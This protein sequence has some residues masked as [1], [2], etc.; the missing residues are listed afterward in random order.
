MKTSRMMSMLGAAMTL[1]A[2]ASA[3][4]PEGGI[5][6]VVAPGVE[7]RLVK[8]GYMFTEGPLG[9]ADGG[10][11]F[12]DLRTANRIYRLD[13]N[14]K[15]SV[16]LEN[17]NN[18]NGLAFT[19]SG[20]LLAAEGGGKRISRIAPDGRVTEVSRG[21][22]ERPLMSPNDLIVDAKDGIYFTDPGPRPV[23][24]GR[25]AYV[26]YLPPGASKAIAQDDAIIRPNGLTI[27]LDGKTLI[28]ADTVGDTLYAFDIHAD[29]SLANRRPFA[30]IQDVPE[31][32]DSGGDGVAIDREG[33]LFV[34]SL[35]GVQVFSRTGDYL[36]TIRVP[37]QPSNVAFSGVDNRTLYITAREG[38]Y[39]IPT[40][41]QGP[42]RRGK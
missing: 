37:R 33:R 32:K 6:D 18:A 42:D 4:Q 20:D 1:C 27:T 16:V 12:T 3:P 36:G 15:I 41:T 40:L 31:G 26:Y 25:K 30:R 19:K 14:G 24:P 34:T 11:L 23:V 21:D 7:A 2:C 22:G 29:G 5:A 13:A 28:V 38:L 10:L 8:E 17:S 9:T 35:T 39:Q